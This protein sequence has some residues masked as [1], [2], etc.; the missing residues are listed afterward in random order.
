MKK[1]LI[2]A[3]ILIVGLTGQVFIS[4]LESQASQQE[5]D[6]RLLDLGNGICEDVVSKQMWQQGVSRRVKSLEHAKEYIRSLNL[7]DY[8]DWR[9]P[10]VSE[11]YDLHITIDLHENG[12]CEIKSE[13]NYWSDEPDSEGHVGAWEMDDNCDPERRYIPKTS[14][15]IRA[16]RDNK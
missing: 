3:G 9:L 11:L 4:S 13:G 6:G 12:N 5:V 10:T 15:R 7:G 14:G 1:L 2:I 16:I 8:N